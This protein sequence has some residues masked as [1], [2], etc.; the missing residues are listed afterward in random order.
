VYAVC[1]SS[2]FDLHILFGSRVHRSL[3]N[4]AYAPRYTYSH[5]NAH[6]RSRTHTNTH[7]Q[8]L[9]RGRVPVCYWPS[10]IPQASP[11]VT[12]WYAPALL[13]MQ[14]SAFPSELETA[15]VPSEGLATWLCQRLLL[16]APVKSTE[17]SCSKG[18]GDHALSLQGGGANLPAGDALREVILRTLLEA[19]DLRKRLELLLVLNG[20]AAGATP[21][22]K[23]SD[24]GRSVCVRR[25]RRGEG[26]SNACLFGWAG[27]SLHE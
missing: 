23:V 7:S 5:A 20:A 2:L 18:T 16:K 21:K 10:D 3:L 27:A 13:Y 6:N 17:E 4:C 9:E 19:G 14:R 11:S 15:G 8:R 12:S 25:C 26:M 24:S 1:T 22:P